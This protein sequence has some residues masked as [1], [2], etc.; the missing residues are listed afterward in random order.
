[1]SPDQP[2]SAA[3]RLRLPV[4][5]S[6]ILHASSLLL[7]LSAAG[8]AAAAERASGLR[9]TVR[10]HEEQ[11]IDGSFGVDFAVTS[12]AGGPFGLVPVVRFERG[13]ECLLAAR[14]TS[15]GD[16]P[17]EL[18]PGESH[19]GRF[20][21][22]YAADRRPF[23]YRRLWL[24]LRAP[25]IPRP[26]VSEPVYVYFTP[27]ETVEVWSAEDF[28]GLQRIWSSPGDRTGRRRVLSR[29]AI[30]ASDLTESELAVPGA[31]V[32]L[33]SLPGLGYSVP[34]RIPRGFVPRILFPGWGRSPF[35]R[36][37]G[38]AA[39]GPRLQAGGEV[40][41]RARRLAIPGAGAAP[42]GNGGNGGGGDV[43]GG[44]GGGGGASSNRFTGTVSGRIFAIVENDLP[45][46]DPTSL[47]IVGIKVELLRKRS[48]TDE[49]I[50]TAFTG[51]GGD[52]HIAFDQTL[53]DPD[54]DVYLKVTAENEASS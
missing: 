13:E 26:V 53:N 34:R 50:G 25:G 18:G 47:D 14:L 6:V 37:N 30:P 31:R 52:V 28:D 36:A 11:V 9:I 41:A 38:I 24:G 1:M 22:A 27:Y 5:L 39:A 29:E 4:V 54:I 43:G 12:F 23:S 33:A 19:T 8:A 17:E 42:D 7:G 45:D 3:R 10:S 48:L 16:P 44:G 20:E 35:V 49:V 32:E 51:E 46:L 21:V 15:G 40:D 2:P